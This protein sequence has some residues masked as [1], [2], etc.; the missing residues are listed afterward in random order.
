[1][2]PAA[3]AVFVSSSNFAIA[4]NQDG[5]LNSLD[6]PANIGSFVTVYFTG[7]GLSDNVVTS[8][9]AAPGNSLS[10]PLAAHRVTIGG[11]EQT[12]Q[13]IGLTPG[14]VGLSQVNVLV[15]AGTP[16]GAQPFVL[17]LNG[18]SSPSSTRIVIAK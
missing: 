3:P 4:Q 16:E 8:G 5:T 15:A 17:E 10:R 2:L 13:F 18:V 9:A 7:Q 6:K 1:M 12:T 14:F 11:R